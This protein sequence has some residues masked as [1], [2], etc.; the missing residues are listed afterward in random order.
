MNQVEKLYT[1][2]ELA[3]IF[4]VSIHTVWRWARTGRINGTKAGKSFLFPES[5]VQRLFDGHVSNNSLNVEQE[6]PTNLVSNK[7]VTFEFEDFTG[8]MQGIVPFIPVVGNKVIFDDCPDCLEYLLEIPDS[9]NGGQLWHDF[10]LLEWEVTGITFLFHYG[11]CC[12][13]VV[14]TLDMLDG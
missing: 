2:K 11:D 9:E 13:E 6:D 7:F 12:D 4:R 10:E 3:G 8:K 14:V 5:E 1:A